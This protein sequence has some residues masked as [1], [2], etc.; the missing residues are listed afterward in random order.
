MPQ[1][2]DAQHLLSISSTARILVLR[3]DRIGDVLV[4]QPFFR[5]L[6]THF[7][8]AEIHVLLGKRNA[9][10]QTFVERYATR[11]LVYRKSLLKMCLLALQLRR[12]RYDLVIDM[13]DNASRTSGLLMRLTA[14]KLRLGFDKENADEYTHLVVRPDRK[15]VH[16]V[17]VM[18]SLMQAFGP[19]PTLDQ[20]RLELPPPPASAAEHSSN[21]R[22]NNEMLPSC[23][24]FLNLSAG[25]QSMWWGSE[26]WIQLVRLLQSAHPQFRIRLGSDAS[27][28][29]ERIRIAQECA[30]ETAEE[31]QD[32]FSYTQQLRCASLVISPDTSIVHLAS[33][34][35]LPQVVLYAK[36]HPD[37]MPWWP[38][39][40]PF[41]ACVSREE[42][43]IQDIE[44]DVVLLAVQKL[45]VRLADA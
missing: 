32:L 43:G 5:L 44:P 21:S 1:I 39:Q 14:A 25:K 40:V 42:A 29:T 28:R 38:F 2:V 31:V 30:C 45:L 24:I 33:A 41:E 16:M 27:R 12:Q 34:L 7:P 8:A 11:T 13:Q 6:R 3:T 22:L 9:V 10:M 15:Q 26:K 23:D 17:Q 4:S 18:A 19:S 35:Q 20:L 36:P 37:R